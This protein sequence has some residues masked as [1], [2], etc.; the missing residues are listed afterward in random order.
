M[1]MELTGEQL[2]TAEIQLTR[3]L[4]RSLPVYGNLVLINRPDNKSDPVQV[5]VDR[6]PEF[7]VVLCKAKYEQ[8]GDLFK[9]ALVFAKDDAILAETVRK[10]S[11]IDW[12][13]FLCLGGSLHQM[14]ISRAVASEKDVSSRTASLCHMM[15]LEDVSKLPSVDSSGMSLSSLDESHVGLVNHMWKF[16]E[17]NEAVRMIQNMVA[18]FPS[19]CV[20]D[21]EGKPVSWI[22]TYGSCAMGM[23]YTLPEHRGK[24]YAKVIISTL[25]KKLHSQGFPVY[26]NIE[27]ENTVS[28]RLFTNLGFTEDPS[29]R[30]TWV[31]F[32]E[33]QAPQRRVS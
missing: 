25:A 20:L 31:G 22:L 32:N 1:A 30:T 19:C 7:S 13:N 15:V 27:E 26:C 33:L 8:E 17:E 16:G 4:P 5:F 10:T 28:Y 12:T 24:G 3:Y 14:E 9:D 18:N 29:F 23:L 11:A 21:Q 2:K 6:W